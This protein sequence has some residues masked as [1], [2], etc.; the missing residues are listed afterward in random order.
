MSERVFLDTSVLYRYLA[1]DDPPRACAAATLIESERT[2]VV[3]GVVILETIYA[4]RTTATR[5]NPELALGLI[6][7]LSRANVELVDADRGH[8]V[9]SLRWTME[10]SARRIPDAIL[11]ASASQAGCDWIATFDE[12]FASPNVP[13]RLL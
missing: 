2:L 10:S 1:E 11:A 3:S 6:S 4:L 13:S 8:V 5:Q 12:A 9:A 7:F